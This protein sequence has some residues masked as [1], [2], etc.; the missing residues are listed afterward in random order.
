MGSPHRVGIV[1][2]GVISSQYLTTLHGVAGIRITAVADLDASRAEAAAGRIDGCR[3]LAVTELLADPDVDTVLN[4]T[5]PAAHAEI[6][7]A[8]LAAGKN[9][10]GEKPLAATLP[11]AQRIMDERGDA[12]VGGA[13][14]TVLGTGIQTA[15]A[16]VDAGLI[17]RPL[18]ATATWV[19]AGHEAWHPH[20]DFYYRDGG[21]PLMDMGPYY[22]TSLVH[23]LGPVVRVTGVSRRARGERVIATG[24]R[25]GERIPVEVDTHV[26]GIL[27]HASGAVSTVVFSFDAV[28]SEARPLEIHG[29]EASLTLPD[30]NMFDGDVALG[31]RGAEWQTLPVSAGYADAGRGIGLIDHTRGGHGADGALAL[32]VLD[33]MASLLESGRRGA[34]LDLVTT[35]ARPAPVPLTAREVWSRGA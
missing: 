34:P 8:A 21:G 13:P 19:S 4:L 28:R 2:L 20:P 5:I 31:R 6:A 16:A 35:V 30:P 3:A 32:H 18:S 10:Y 25:A 22:L 9:V 27:E 1:G 15:R 11:D 7:L 29:E 24:P 23:L 12:W 26:T 14:D 33:I 17:G